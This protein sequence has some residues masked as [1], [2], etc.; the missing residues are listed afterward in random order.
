MHS[1]ARKLRPS[2]PTTRSIHNDLE[3]RHRTCTDTE[4]P[5]ATSSRPEESRITRGCGDHVGSG[6]GCVYYK[7]P[8]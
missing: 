4:D 2:K 6:A 3:E 1:F 7:S 5:V 8:P